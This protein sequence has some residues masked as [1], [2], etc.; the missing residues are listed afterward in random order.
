M[1]SWQGRV[2][3]HLGYSDWLPVTQHRVDLF[4][5]ATGD[6][7]WI[8]VDPERAAGSRFG[9]TIAHG[10]LVL[11]L[12]PRLLDQV[13][14]GA[15]APPGRTS[16]NLGFHRVRFLT[17][18]PVGSRLRLGATLRSTSQ[19]AGGTE[20]LFAVTLLIEGRS[21]PVCVAELLLGDYA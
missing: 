15:G 17:P 7:Q 13:L 8:H 21:A 9:G 12:V 18:V 2:G 20:S 10:L 16:V 1:T 14:R 3:S 19:V 6:D 5:E 4:A 11:S